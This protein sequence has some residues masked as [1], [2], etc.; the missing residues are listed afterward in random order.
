MPAW[1]ERL[2]GQERRMPTGESEL[3][4]LRGPVPYL[5]E[6]AVLNLQAGPAVLTIR[7]AA[8]VKSNQ[9]GV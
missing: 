5:A 3:A 6:P 4:R 1:M 8:A 2:F 9:R 7:V